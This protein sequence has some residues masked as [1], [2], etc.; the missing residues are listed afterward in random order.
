MLTT[1]NEDGAVRVHSTCLDVGLAG[2]RG[3]HSLTENPSLRER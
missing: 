3:T 1:V 2:V